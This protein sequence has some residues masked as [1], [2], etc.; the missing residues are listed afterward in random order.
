MVTETVSNIYEGCYQ[1]FHLNYN[2]HFTWFDII[3][4]SQTKTCGIIDKTNYILSLECKNSSIFTQIQQ[5]NYILN[6]NQNLINK[7]FVLTLEMRDMIRQSKTTT[8]FIKS[9]S[10]VIDYVNMIKLVDYDTSGFINQQL[11]ILGVCMIVAIVA[12]LLAPLIEYLNERRII[13]K[14]NKLLL[15]RFN[16]QELE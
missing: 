16:E 1:G 5:F 6:K 10:V 11:I 8:L 9:D 3:I 4:N 14:K 2:T 15:K 7:S 13:R 12:A